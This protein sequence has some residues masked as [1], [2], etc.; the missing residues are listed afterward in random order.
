MWAMVKFER[1]GLLFFANLSEKSH[2][3]TLSFW[4]KN[5]IWREF[6]LSWECGWVSSLP[7]NWLMVFF[8]PILHCICTLNFILQWKF[9]LMAFV[10]VLVDLY[11]LSKDFF[12]V[13]C[14][15][16]LIV[17]SLVEKETI[18]PHIF[19]SIY[20]KQSSYI[21][22]LRPLTFFLLL[23][24]FWHSFGI[25]S[26]TFCKIFP[27]SNLLQNKQITTCIF[28]IHIYYVRNDNESLLPFSIFFNH[29]LK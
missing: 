18:I 20:Y 1:Q 27:V 9:W 8:I 5:S 3:F 14:S 26:S 21:F 11:A 6:H 4:K 10:F 23:F 16:V 7:C 12:V 25:F 19:I 17:M 13:Y 22:E 2:P 24:L 28:Y 15:W 29:Y